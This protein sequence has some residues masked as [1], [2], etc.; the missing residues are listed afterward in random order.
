MANSITVWILRC[1]QRTDLRLV[2]LLKE[3]VTDDNFSLTMIRSKADA[4]FLRVQYTSV[5]TFAS[6]LICNRSLETCRT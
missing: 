3:K 6:I 2:F 1:T 4:P 5:I